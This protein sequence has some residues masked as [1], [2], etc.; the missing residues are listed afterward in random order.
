M[1]AVGGEE[2]YTIPYFSNCLPDVHPV[3]KHS[4]Q[5]PV[6]CGMKCSRTLEITI[7][8]FYLCTCSNIAMVSEEPT[9][10]SQAHT[11]THYLWECDK[12]EPCHL[13]YQ[14]LL[15]PNLWFMVGIMYIYVSGNLLFTNLLIY[16]QD[17]SVHVTTNMHKL[18]IPC[19]HNHVNHKTNQT[20]CY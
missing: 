16:I 6:K 7:S 19:H 1:G 18:G 8:T 11:Y 10:S 5:T 20:G 17:T 13:Y 9:L 2:L 12:T 3:N 15:P 4:K 14:Q